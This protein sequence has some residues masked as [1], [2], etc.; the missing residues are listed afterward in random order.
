MLAMAGVFLGLF[1]LAEALEVPLLTDPSPWLEGGKG[2]AAFVGFALL[3]LDV[4]L[5]VP[6]SLV[7]IAHGALFGVVLGTAL[8]LLGGMAAAAL[9]FFIGR[10]S[11][12]WLERLVSEEERRRAD[13]WLSRYGEVAVVASRPVPI[14]AE[15]VAILAGTS[16]M[17][18]AR[19]LLA[20]FAGYIPAALLYALTGATAARLDSALLVFTLVIAITGVFWWVGRRRPA[21]DGAPETP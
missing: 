11:T 19:F 20:S 14:L 9:G 3:T 10:R 2:L 4:L 18:W 1:G 6:A 12:V 16:S 7:M 13:L 15:S 21:A 8:S 5:P 17:G